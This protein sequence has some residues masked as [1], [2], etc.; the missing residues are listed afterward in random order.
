MENVPQSIGYIT[1]RARGIV[2]FADSVDEGNEPDARPMRGTVTFTP[3]VGTRP[4]VAIQEDPKLLFTVETVRTE[5]DDEGRLRPP[6]DGQKPPIDDEG[7]LRL[8]AP[9]QPD[10]L[11]VFGWTWT[12]NFRPAQ[13]QQWSAFSVVFRGAPGEEIDLVDLYL[14]QRA[15]SGGGF[16]PIIHKVPGPWNPEVDPPPLGARPGEY[17]LDES[18]GAMWLLRRETSPEFLVT[19]VTNAVYLDALDARDDAERFRNETEQRYVLVGDVSGAV[20]L[21]DAIGD[22]PAGLD[23]TLT[24]DVVATLPDF[25]NRI[26][27]C[28]IYA[29]QDATGDRALIIQDGKTSWSV[30]I[31]LTPEPGAHDLIHLLHYGPRGWIVLSGAPYLGVPEGWEQ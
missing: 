1:V 5:F 9:D 25:G 6:A 20:D 13:G 19:W 11:S 16:S 29:E 15:S 21:T 4:L 10:S 8:V 24:G 17:V 3:G 2:A 27:T 7:R 26:L 23:I 28:S 14:E 12:A 18:T 30:P 22:S 31:V